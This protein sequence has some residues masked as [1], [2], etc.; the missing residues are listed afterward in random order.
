[1]ILPKK[2]KPLRYMNS[3]SIWILAAVSFLASVSCG[4]PKETKADAVL[5]SAASSLEIVPEALEVPPANVEVAKVSFRKVSDENTYS[6]SVLP[7][8]TNN[9]AP[10]SASRI[11]KI[12]VEV[13][14]YV[15]KGKVLAEMDR[16]QLE[17]TRLQL[18]NDSVE[19][20]RLKSLVDEGGIAQ[21]DFDAIELAY[22]VRKTTYQNLLENTVLKS[23]ITGFVT[24]RNYDVNDL[25]SMQMP[26]FTI[27]QVVPVKLL[28]GISESQYT[29]VKE[30]D[31]VSITVDAFPGRT[32][33]GKVGRVYPTVNSAT[34]TFNTEVIVANKDKALRP[35][36]Y[37]RVTVNFGDTKSAVVPDQAVV[38][39]EGTGQRFVY[40]LNDDD[41]VTLK[42]VT[43][44]RHVGSEYQI[45]DGI[46]EGETIVV[47]GHAALKDGSRVNVL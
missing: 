24:A 30:G 36:M 11:R 12:N 1:M 4:G 13:G 27:Q 32:F 41:T 46:S 15:W 2:M 6:S 35:G 43:I 16:L 8:A 14:D 23:P 38:K 5:G 33:S 34:H 17:Q 7:Y 37:A 47:K 44:G 42:P 39:L 18:Q 19:Y 25:Y 3:K 22:S 28:V 29:K 31:P 26:L 20:F 10:Q 21:S 45:L 40:I 9:I